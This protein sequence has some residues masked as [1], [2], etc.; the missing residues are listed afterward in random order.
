VLAAPAQAT[1]E[2]DYLGILASTPGFTV[3]P[4]TGPLLLGAGNTICADLRAGM[5]PADSAAKM[6]AYPGATN[7]A[8]VVMVSA[9]RQTL[10]PDVKG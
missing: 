1:P 5:S 7:A 2:D 3:N 4:F 8:T 10:C 9:A 6:M